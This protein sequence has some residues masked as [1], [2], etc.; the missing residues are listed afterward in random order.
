M[1][2]N[3]LSDDTRAMY[4]YNITR[5]VSDVWRQCMKTLDDA[6]SI[7]ITFHR[8]KVNEYH[9][10]A[11]IA[12][13]ELLLREYLEHYNVAKDDL[14]TACCAVIIFVHCINSEF[15]D[16]ENFE[17]WER[18]SDGKCVKKQVKLTLLAF[19]RFYYLYS[20]NSAL[21]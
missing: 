6:D 2:W 13:F 17:F 21:I 20:K 1:L 12:K 15:G 3:E 10:D 19:M 18:M 9:Y 4:T 14:Q 16:C 5:W 11:I 7:H 8:V